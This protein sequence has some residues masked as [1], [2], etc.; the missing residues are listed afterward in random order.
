MLVQS[1]VKSTENQTELT[2]S[3]LSAGNSL[4][5]GQSINSDNGWFTL[6]FQTDGN[7][8]LYRN[9]SSQKVL[10]A[11]GTENQS[12]SICTMQTDGNLCIYSID[13]KVLFNTNT[14]DYS[15]SYLVVQDDGNM[16]IYQP[17]IFINSIWSTN[18]QQSQLP[19]G[20]SLTPG[21]FIFSE[22]RLYTLLFQTDGNLVL[23]NGQREVLWA[24]GTEN[25]S[26]ANCIMQADGNFAI[27]S[28]NNSLLF[29]SNTE[30][31]PESYL[32]LQNDG[33]V[34]IYQASN[35]GAVWTTNTENSQLQT[36]KILALGQS[37]TSENGLYNLIFQ[38][39]GN[40]VLYA[41]YPPQQMLFAT[42]TEKKY[43]STCIMQEDG[44][45]VIYN[46][47]KDV[48]WATN[49]E[50]NPG[51]YLVVQNDGNVC[52]YNSTGSKALFCTNTVQPYY[53]PK[54]DN[55]SEVWE[56]LKTNHTTEKFTFSKYRPDDLSSHF[57]GMSMCKSNNIASFTHSGTLGI[58]WMIGQTVFPT[59][60]MGSI[61]AIG[62]KY[63]DNNYKHPGGFQIANHFAMIPIEKDAV[64]KPVSFIQL[65][66]FTT[67]IFANG[68]PVAMPFSIFRP[69]SGA[70]CTAMIY[71][72][73]NFI[74]YFVVYT[75]NFESN[76]SPTFDVYSFNENGG[77]NAI[78]YL[79]SKSNLPFGY[80]NISLVMQLDN[81]PYLIGLRGGGEDYGDLYQLDIPGQNI[82][83]VGSPKYFYTPPTEVH[84][85]FRYGASVN[86]SMS[87]NNLYV[88]CCQRTLLAPFHWIYYGER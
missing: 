49:T 9:Y 19:S 56:N 15:D 60:N 8:V 73:V 59:N 2:Q 28:T 10:W 22:N 67:V 74:Y 65:Y 79:F 30:G 80:D 57:Q 81:T 5:P 84:P 53:Y 32:T 76:G 71:D 58:G 48:L 34:C 24:S 63:N 31:Y 36:G 39:D 6:V 14:A 86:V 21:Q 42:Q 18:T 61:F 66:D 82:Q 54:L 44:N 7:L 64:G 29:A 50:G 47:N 88:Y 68:A 62:I 1:Q 45:L 55:V 78:Q 33:N 37:L 46:D 40:F 26:A 20:Q 11:T 52:L 77:T 83:I 69:T 4:T 25:Q 3:Q 43:A 17:D 70:S 12:A 16:V 41:T 13:N 35:G 72:D 87:G 51:S 85:S 27:Y 38:L 23:L 75:S